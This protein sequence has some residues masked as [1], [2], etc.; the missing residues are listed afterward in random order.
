LEVV[1]AGIKGQ[2]QPDAEAFFVIHNKTDLGVTAFMLTFGDVSVGQEG[3]LSLSTDDPEVVIEPHGETTLSFPLSNLEKDVPIFVSGVFY[4][5]GS[6]DG[7]PIILQWMHED[8]ADE[9]AKR[10]AKKGPPKQ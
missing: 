3:G 9:K 6:E 10:D 4:A 7:L 5:D 1:N 2:G 8:R